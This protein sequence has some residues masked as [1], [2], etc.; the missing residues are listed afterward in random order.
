MEN[1][2]HLVKLEI[3]LLTGNRISVIE[4]IDNLAKLTIFSI[5]DNII[6][7]WEHVGIKKFLQICANILKI[8]FP[9]RLCIYGN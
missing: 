7:E 3:L 4:K 5:A 6:E 8:N 2:N 9:I 1:L